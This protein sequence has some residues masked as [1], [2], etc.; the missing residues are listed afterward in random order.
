MILVIEVSSEN[1]ELL[2]DVD[3]LKN[4]ANVSVPIFIGIKKLP[5]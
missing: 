3:S 4:S 5:V 1:V 2:F